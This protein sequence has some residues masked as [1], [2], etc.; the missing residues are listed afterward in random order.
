M[1]DNFD[2]RVVFEAPMKVDDGHGGKVQG[3]TPENEALKLWAKFR[4]LR[5]GET[6]QAARL[7][8]RQPV[9]VTVRASARSKAIQ[10]SWRMRDLRSGEVYNVRTAPVPTDDR[11]YLE[12]TAEGGVA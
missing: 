12:I 10:T 8:G 7:A 1:T 9:V 6:V 5:G 2:Q 11:Q 4:Y 3:W